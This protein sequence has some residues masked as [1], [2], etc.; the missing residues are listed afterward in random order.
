MP[1]YVE[2]SLSNFALS[3]TERRQ[4]QEIMEAMTTVQSAIKL[5]SERQDA[6]ATD[7]KSHTIVASSQQCVARLQSFVEQSFASQPQ[8]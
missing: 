8:N 4:R 6:L 3:P 1:T 5:L 7:L 2:N